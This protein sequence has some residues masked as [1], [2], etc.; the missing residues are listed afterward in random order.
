[1]KNWKTTSTGIVMIAAG[2]CGFYFAMLNKQLSEATI[3]AS[4]TSVL[5]G[6]GLIFAKDDNVTGGTI[7]NEP[8]DAKTVKSAAKVDQ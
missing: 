6:L 1:M 8:N 3:T 7:V 5:G 4:M 2:I